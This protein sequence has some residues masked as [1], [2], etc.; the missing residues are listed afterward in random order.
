MRPYKASGPVVTDHVPA[1]T[2]DAPV[3]WSVVRTCKNGQSTLQVGDL[4]EVEKWLTF[5]VSQYASGRWE[6]L[7]SSQ[8]YSHFHN[9]ETRE[10]HILSIQPC[11]DIQFN[12]WFDDMEYNL[13]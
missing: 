2:L 5:E 6:L 10:H 11:S 12:E 8:H 1:V 4:D 7:N 3:N 13:G 9:P